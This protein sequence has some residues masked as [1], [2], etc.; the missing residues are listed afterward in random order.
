MAFGHTHKPYH[1]V[2]A[3]LHEGQTFYRHA[4]N[5]GSVGK[6]KDGDPRS[7]YVMLHVDADSHMQSPD[8]I[9]AEFIRVAYDVEKAARAI[10]KSPLPN[11]FADMLRKA[12]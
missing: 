11:A 1:R 9:Q 6:P 8:G 5:I 4:I 7:C 3:Y 12:Y 2:L 10:E